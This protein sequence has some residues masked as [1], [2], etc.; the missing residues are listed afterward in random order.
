MDNGTCT[1]SWFRFV[2]PAIH[3]KIALG[4]PTKPQRRKP[5][6]DL[7]LDLYSSFRSIISRIRECPNIGQAELGMRVLM[8]LHFAYQPLKLVELQHA[9]AVGNSDT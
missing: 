3:I 4:M 1:D 7:P 6:K 9:L 2:L 5:L 8:W